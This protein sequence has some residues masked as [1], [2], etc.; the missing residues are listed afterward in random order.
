V[1]LRDLDDYA[2]E[3]GAL[4]HADIAEDAS[5]ALG[6][7]SAF[8][9]LG[10]GDG[11]S[12]VRPCHGTA[13]CDRLAYWVAQPKTTRSVPQNRNGCISTNCAVGRW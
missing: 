11:C 6:T 4:A 8:G 5:W 13:G 7:L 1:L 2:A 3:R 9:L 10:W 12:N